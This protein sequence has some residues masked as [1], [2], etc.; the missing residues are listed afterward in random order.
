MKNEQIKSIIEFEDLLSLQVSKFEQT[1]SCDD[2]PAD[3]HDRFELRRTAI[4]PLAEEVLRLRDFVWFDRLDHAHK[5]THVLRLLNEGE[6]SLA[7][8]CEWLRA[9]A[10]GNE[11]PIVD[12]PVG[13][14]PDDMSFAEVYAEMRRLR[15][16]LD[17]I[18][19]GTAEIIEA[20]GG[21]W[22]LEA[23][24][25]EN[26]DD[27]PLAVMRLMRDEQRKM[28]KEIAA[29]KTGARADE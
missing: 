5:P 9:Y 26:P 19:I 21:D 16:A 14:V 12:V 20:C 8:A 1:G 24:D 3:I 17:R 18:E 22:V 10:A 7:K 27:F 4:K 6:I 29:L 11:M 15:A 13:N 23:W 28:R 2:P 25:E